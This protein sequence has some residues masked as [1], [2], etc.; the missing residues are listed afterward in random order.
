MQVL[1][2]LVVVYALSY[3]LQ[4]PLEPF[5]V[6]R[7]VQGEAAASYA[8]LQSFFAM[9]QMLG[10]LIVGHLIDAIGLR[11]A[12]VLNFGACAASYALLANASTIHLL[13]LSKVPTIFQT[14]FLCAQTAA[15]KLTP[16][17]PSRVELLGRLTMAYTIG[18]TVGPSLGGALGVEASAWLAV[19]LSVL[20]MASVIV[21][22][23]GSV[24]I[25]EESR[26]CTSEQSSNSPPSSN[27]SSQSS[28]QSKPPTSRPLST[29]VDPA[30]VTRRAEASS[31]GRSGWWSRA[32]TVLHCVWFF[33]MTK[34]VCGAVNS[35]QG[36]LQPFVL[37]DRFG[38]TEALVGLFMSARFFGTAVMG[39]GLGR[40][41]T[42]LRGPQAVIVCCL[43]AMSLGFGS[44][45]AILLRT[46]VFTAASIQD[47]LVLDT[48]ALYVLV[49]FGLALF[50]FPLATTI[51][52][53][54]TSLVP[55]DV[56]GTLVGME[57]S[58]YAAAAMVG[59][60]LGV[61]LME[62]FGLSI[63][64]AAAGAVYAAV[65]TAWMFR[66]AEREEKRGAEVFQARE[67]SARDGQ[68]WSATPEK[69]KES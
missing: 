31:A 51:T 4:A 49:S 13:Y 62:A 48:R 26:A 3:Q 11:G 39:M 15:A 25:S 8:R 22:L 43:L 6:D 37:K 24:D 64:A 54:T 28:A 16:P 21:F 14:G 9:I 20:A 45:A 66:Q 57:H 58:L 40:L 17:G 46:D 68:D 41:T 61:A 23:P 34:F 35:M 69:E 12:F 44:I 63:V 36:S 2:L 18:A 27:S 56:K 30:V 47:M 53:C 19:A 55:P 67:V 65:W 60:P 52:A 59:P 32:S 42:A 50:Q 38:L 10:S 7:L 29:S 5:L 1:L 33:L